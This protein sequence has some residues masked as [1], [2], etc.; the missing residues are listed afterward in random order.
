MSLRDQIVRGGMYLL[1]RQGI[2]MVLSVVGV[3]LLTR[4]IG[5]EGYGLYAG[6]LSMFMFLFLV[7]QWGISVYLVRHEG[8][9]QDSDYHQASS[10]LLL[11]GV[12]GAA[13][14]SS[15][16]PLLNRWLSIE[17]FGPV[18]LALFAG[19]P[20]T[21]LRLVPQA[22]LERALDFRRVAMVELL[23]QAVYYLTALPLAYQGLGPWSPVAGWWVQQLLATVLLY[24]MAKYRPRIYWEPGRARTMIGYGLSYSAST[25]VYNARLLVNPLVV[26][27]YAGAEAMGYVALTIRVIEIL[28]FAKVAIWRLSI[29]ALGRLQRDGARLLSALSQGMELQILAVGPALVGF[30]LVGPWL[31]P[32]LFGSDWL[33]VLSIFPFLAAAKLVDSIFSLHSS[34]LYVLRRNWD[35]TIFH[36][37]HVLLFIGGAL[38]FVPWQGIE[39]YGWAEVLAL[40]SYPVI[41]LYVVREVG[42]PSYRHAVVW[43]AAFALALFWQELGW[44]AASGLVGIALWPETWRALRKYAKDM[45]RVLRRRVLSE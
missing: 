5:P 37:V 27:G 29:A 38:L 14:A 44:V 42:R 22:R 15:I 9:L 24:R 13:L 12:T 33:P 39:G 4:A 1:V 34:V 18:A 43:T 26:G 25:W 10:L 6:P 21:L 2:G 11:L 17:G 40:M 7:L 31:M 23:G 35:M 45:R 32:P 3:V 8:D 41:H 36:L 30:G 20:I 19:L 28:A 16:M